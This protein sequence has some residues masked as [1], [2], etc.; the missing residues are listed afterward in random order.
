MSLQNAEHSA[1]SP[2][3]HQ[4]LALHQVELQPHQQALEQPVTL[5]QSDKLPRDQQGEARLL[6]GQVAANDCDRPWAGLVRP[7]GQQR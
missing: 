7:E 1:S 6:A 4:P 2:A 3:A 5:A